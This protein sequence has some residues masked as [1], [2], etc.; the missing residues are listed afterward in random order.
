MRLPFP[1]RVPVIPEVRDALALGPAAPRA[2]GAPS[3]R[4]AEGQLSSRSSVSGGQRPCG[5]WV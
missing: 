1:S 3:V 2:A 4:R 5:L